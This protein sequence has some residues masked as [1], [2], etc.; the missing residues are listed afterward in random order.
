MPKLTRHQWFESVLEVSEGYNCLGLT[1]NFPSP[2]VKLV[3]D[4]FQLVGYTSKQAKALHVPYK[5]AP[6]GIG[7]GAKKEGRDA[8]R[9]F[10]PKT[11]VIYG[12][13]VPDIGVFWPFFSGSP[14]SP[15]YTT[16]CSDASL[17]LSRG[18]VF[19]YRSSYNILNE[20]FNDADWIEAAALDLAE[21]CTSRV[22][23]NRSPNPDLK[24]IYKRANGFTIMS[25]TKHEGINPYIWTPAKM[26][27]IKRTL[28]GAR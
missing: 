23:S 13:I 16:T 12:R 3:Y 4:K 1:L 26:P 14:K 22:L 6:P 27:T 7:W 17:F 18:F 9:A 25:N 20:D 15:K 8:I 28:F 19:S 5:L 11:L 10:R 2:L 21:I 24:E